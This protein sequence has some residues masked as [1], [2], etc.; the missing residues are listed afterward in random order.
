MP[1]SPRRARSPLAARGRPRRSPA[2]SASLP[3]VGG[4][5]PFGQPDASQTIAQTAPGPEKSRSCEAGVPAAPVRPAAGGGTGSRRT[6]PAPTWV[7]PDR[8]R[9]DPAPGFSGPRRSVRPD[10]RRRDPI[11][12]GALAVPPSAARPRAADPAPGAAPSCA[13]PRGTVDGRAQAA[14][15]GAEP[16]WSDGRA[17]PEAAGVFAARPTRAAP[18]A[19]LASG[20]PAPRQ[21]HRKSAAGRSVRRRRPRPDGARPR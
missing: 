4:A 14:V 15:D 21:G 10:R 20:H 19:V 18:A 6:L 16:P 11:R 13:Q 3:R 2:R 8:G 1:G 7:R 5:P 12:R 9:R 17:R